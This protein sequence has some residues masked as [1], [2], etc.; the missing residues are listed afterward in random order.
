MMYHK[1]G[2]LSCFSD[3][4]TKYWVASY[5]MGTIHSEQN[6]EAWRTLYDVISWSKDWIAVCTHRKPELGLH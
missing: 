2:K 4:K 6:K 1:E 5:E 3:T